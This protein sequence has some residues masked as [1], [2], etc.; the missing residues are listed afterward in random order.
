M[1]DHAAS[2]PGSFWQRRKADVAVWALTAYVAVLGVFTVNDIFRLDLLEWEVFTPELHTWV[3]KQIHLLEV[4]PQA[5]EAFPDRGAVERRLTELRDVLA[6]TRYARVVTPG[7]LEDELNQHLAAGIVEPDEAAREKA[8]AFYARGQEEARRRLAEI[9][10]WVTMPIFVRYLDHDSERVRRE[11]FELLKKVVAE[12]WATPQTD[13][14]Q[15][16]NFFGYDPA[17]P[18]PRRLESIRLWKAWL[19]TLDLP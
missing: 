6:R 19:R 7:T 9:E 10:D 12:L 14:W 2:G 15:R 17:A 8:R 1:S 5:P 3:Y 11:V 18:R 13:A 4:D 16:E